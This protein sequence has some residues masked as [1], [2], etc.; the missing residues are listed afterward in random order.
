MTGYGRAQARLPL[1]GF[2]I[3]VRSV[4]GR[5]LDVRVNLPFADAELETVLV[6][7]LRDRLERGRIDVTVVEESSEG[8]ARVRPNLALASAHRD[9]LEAIRAGLGLPDPVRLELIAAQRGVLEMVPAGEPE[10]IHD[11][12]Q[13]G[14]AEALEGLVRSRAEEGAALVVDLRARV[15]AI[16]EAAFRLRSAAA[17]APEAARRRLQARLDELLGSAARVDP[18]RLATEVALLATRADVHEE[19]VRMESHLDRV[20]ALLGGGGPVGR[21][22]DFLCQELGREANTI[23]AKIDDLAAVT[24]MLQIK[25]EVERMREQAQNLE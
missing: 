5:Y 16:R 21:K 24:E 3:E 8:A 25:V 12:V 4:N 2:R 14:V 20:D 10:R 7:L 6:R 17:A 22:L 9:A 19:L 11:A 15:A 23:S 18:A 13:R 1:G